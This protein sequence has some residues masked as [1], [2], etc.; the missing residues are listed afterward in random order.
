MSAGALTLSVLVC[1]IFDAVLWANIEAHFLKTLALNLF[2]CVASAG[3]GRSAG[4]LRAKWKLARTIKKIEARLTGRSN[5][6]KTADLRFSQ[7]NS[8]CPDA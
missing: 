7:E 8:P 3:L 4:L 2:A 6:L 1:G 5:Y